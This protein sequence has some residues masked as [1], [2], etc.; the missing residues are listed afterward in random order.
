MERP[1][2]K[3]TALS[4]VFKKATSEQLPE[5]YMMGYD[6]WGGSLEKAEYLLECGSSP[7]YKSG[8]WFV[9]EADLVPV[10]SLLVHGFSP[11]GKI[12]IRGIGSLATAREFRNIGYGH[13]IVKRAVRYLYEHE[14]AA[15][16]FLFSDIDPLF[17]RSLG[18]RELPERHQKVSQSVLM[19]WTSPAIEASV[20]DVNDERLP[21][22]F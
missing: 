21:R 16:I 22:Y 12:Q 10:S 20:F 15:V 19:A 4:T 9:L 18:F 13:Q 5:I 8:T 6:A 17:Y 7:K 3:R 1:G 11:W 14:S 2:R